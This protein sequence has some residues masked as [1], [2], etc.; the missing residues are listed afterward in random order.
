MAANPSVQSMAGK[1]LVRHGTFAMSVKSHESDSPFADIHEIP[2]DVFPGERRKRA[3]A[4][5]H[6]NLR[7]FQPG[8]GQTV[9]TITQNLSSDGCYCLV[10][11]VFEPG[12]VRYC[13]LSVPTHYPP[14]SDR[15]RPMICR[16]RVVRVELLG[17]GDVYGVG[18]RIEDYR[19]ASSTDIL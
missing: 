11:A 7:F 18:C 4:Q 8:G 6:W 9:D 19:F 3:R 16:V 15:V 2:G 12:E 10:D 14:A 13:M 5:V 1:M 17:P